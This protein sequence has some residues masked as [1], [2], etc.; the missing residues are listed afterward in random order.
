MKTYFGLACKCCNE[1]PESIERLISL[2]AVSS[3]VLRDVLSWLKAN[4][5]VLESFLVFR[6]FFGKTVDFLIIKHALLLGKYYVYVSHGMPWKFTRVERLYCHD[7][8]YL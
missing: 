2:V 1:G 8:T 3:E 6:F 7:K 4:N 5:V